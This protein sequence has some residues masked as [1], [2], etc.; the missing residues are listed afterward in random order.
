MELLTLS[1]ENFQGLKHE[2]IQ[3]DGHSASIYG[4]NASGKTTIFNAI[5]W[6]L[7]ASRAPG[8]RTGTPRQRDPTGICTTWNTAQPAPSGWTTA[9]L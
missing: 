4:R 3:L 7:L 5:T 6:L 1:L 8:R 9:R 2:E